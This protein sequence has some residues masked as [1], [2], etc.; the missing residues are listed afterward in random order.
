MSNRSKPGR[1][2]IRDDFEYDYAPAAVAQD[3]AV[4]LAAVA[5]AAEAEK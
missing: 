5:A 4:L 1:I 2:E 3:A